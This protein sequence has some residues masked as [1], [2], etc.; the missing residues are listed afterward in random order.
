MNYCAA[1]KSYDAQ[2]HDAREEFIPQF[3]KTI[4]SLFCMTT[5][6][7][8][9][10]LTRFSK[11]MRMSANAAPL[12]TARQTPIDGDKLEDIAGLCLSGGGYRAMLFHAGALFRMNE[13]GLLPKLARISGVSGGSMATGALAACWGELVFDAVGRATNLIQLFL[14]PVLAQANSSIDVSA[15]LLGLLPFVTPA[16]V[17]ARSYDANFARKL[18]LKDLPKTPLFVFNATSLMSGKTLRMRPDYVAD[19]KVGRMENVKLSLAEAVAAS[20]SFPPLLSPARLSFSGAKRIPDPVD[21][22][23]KPPYTEQAVVTD[24][25]VYDNMGTETVWKRCRTVFVS[26]AGRPFDAQEA[27]AGNWPQQMLR[28]LEIA[29]SQSEDLRE[30]ILMHAF[31]IKARQGAMWGLSPDKPPPDL[32]TAQEY[33]A[34]R[35]LPTRLTRFSQADQ[36]LA[37][38][39]GYACATAQLRAWYGP[40][41]GGVPDVPN[42]QWPTP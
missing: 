2:S 6:W 37:L 8:H 36:A 40:A 31:E 39:A 7:L 13:L 42:G 38:K 35:S 20:A 17:V 25:G 11:V 4:H 34:A 3:S 12:T 27:P 5:A 22:L 18:M 16:Q 41:H 9:G 28:V 24:G 23:S 21:P 19:Q 1:N 15:T 14:K 29:M 10:M 33:A 26:N 30:R 32:L